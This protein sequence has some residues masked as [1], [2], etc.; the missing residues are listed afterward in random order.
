MLAP[1]ALVALLI[2]GSQA[3]LIVSEDDAAENDHPQVAQVE[4]VRSPFDPN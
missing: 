3:V 4:T 1:L 2:G